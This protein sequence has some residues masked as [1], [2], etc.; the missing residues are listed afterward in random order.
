MSNSAAVTFA[1]EANAGSQPSSQASPQPQSH[2]H[3]H[4]PFRHHHADEARSPPLSSS[5]PLSNGSPHNN[6]M[7]TFSGERRSPQ[8]RAVSSH[9]PGPG[10]PGQNNAASGNNVFGRVVR[11]LSKRVKPPGQRNESEPNEPPAYSAITNTGNDSSAGSSSSHVNSHRRGVSRDR[12]R[13]PQGSM[14]SERRP[15]RRPSF[16]WG[17]PPLG[18][19]QP[20]EDPAPSP[21]AA[22]ASSAAHQVAGRNYPVASRSVDSLLSLTTGADV[23]L[24]GTT[25]ANRAQASAA[26]VP[27]KQSA[28]T[29]SPPGYSSKPLS[30]P[31]GFDPKKG[32]I[33]STA[34][35]K[36]ATD[37]PVANVQSS[38][39]SAG[40]WA[41]RAGT[42]MDV[43]FGLPG[44]TG[45]T[46]ESIRRQIKERA[47]L[48]GR[49]PYW[50]VQRGWTKGV[51]TSR[52]EADKRTRNFPGPVVRYF[53]ENQLD[54]AL[55]FVKAGAKPAQVAD[56][57]DEDSIIRRIS[58]NAT[59][60][61]RSVSLMERK[62]EYSDREAKLPIV[63]AL[64]WV[65]LSAPP[66]CS[67]TPCRTQQAWKRCTAVDVGRSS[68]DAARAQ[69]FGWGQRRYDHHRI[70]PGIASRLALCERHHRSNARG[71]CGTDA[72]YNASKCT[73]GPA[74]LIGECR[75]QACQRHHH[76]ACISSA[77][78]D[79]L[80]HHDTRL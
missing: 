51:V 35:A 26:K 36:P 41:P 67:S 29:A 55:A 65:Y 70:R 12:F 11:K 43:G 3:H 34:R 9:A 32:K 64:T 17:P 47:A 66:S 49:G 10:S 5:S 71:R 78:L 14:R 76:P 38:N 13:N 61:G 20:L 18:S 40:Y 63:S 31:L 33:S 59:G 73:E 8:I 23:P 79:L 16:E 28:P 72:G 58:Q 39:Y 44:D 75:S 60:L 15:A 50:A 57:D 37:A 42:S 25:P 52:E 46:D 54:E 4:N 74:H 45:E 80:L 19:D 22:A 21:R 69:T 27:S 48:V 7:R 56:D 1:D 62:C 24:V 30:P 6:M 68:C 2:A 53:E 77:L